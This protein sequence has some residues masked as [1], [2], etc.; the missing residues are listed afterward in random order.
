MTLIFG[1]FFGK[2]FHSGVHVN[3]TL[4]EERET[5]RRNNHVELEVVETHNYQVRCKKIHVLGVF[6]S[7]LACQCGVGCLQN[8]KDN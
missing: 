2:T 5:Q 6:A 7:C 8:Q 4:R 1:L 3:T